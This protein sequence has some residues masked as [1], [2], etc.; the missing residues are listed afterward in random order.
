MALELQLTTANAQKALNQI[1]SSLG[2][3]QTKLASFSGTSSLETSLQRIAAI[4]FDGSA[5]SA[6]SKLSTALNSL[7]SGGN[8]T[9]VSSELNTLANVKLNGV[10][11]SVSGLGVALKG[12]RAPS[13]MGAVASGFQSIGNAAAAASGSVNAFGSAL[14]G[15]HA[16][17]G[18][19]GAASGMQNVARGAQS[20]GTAVQGFG[21]ALGGVS[22]VLNGFGI[23]L[24]GVGL[25]QFARAAYSASVAVTQF[26]SR[27]ASTGDG[28]LNAADQLDYVRKAADALALPVNDAGKAYSKLLNTLGSNADAVEKSR[29]IFEGFGTAFR[30]MGL[31]AEQAKR[32]FQALDQ[33]MSKGT[34]SME[35]LKQQLG[36]LFPA[37]NDLAKSMGVSAAELS[38]MIEQGKVGSDVMGKFADDLREK[39]GRGLAQALTSPQAA[40]QRLENAATNALAEIGKT[41]Y[42]A[43]VPAIDELT[44]ALKQPDF[45]ATAKSA[46]ELAGVLGG[47][48]VQAAK[49]VVENFRLIASVVAALI[50][51]SVVSWATGAAIAIGTV[52]R[53]A[54]V[55]QP[56]VRAAAMSMVL[57]TSSMTGSSAA[58]AASSGI[59]ARIGAAFAAFNPVVRAAIVVMTLLGA[60]FGYLSGDVGSFESLWG[61]FVSRLGSTIDSISQFFSDLGTSIGSAL[62]YAAQVIS[63]WVSS[64]GETLSGWASGVAQMF[65][66]FF[67]FLGQLF[68]TGLNAVGQL[69]MN[70][71]TRVGQIFGTVKQTLVDFANSAVESFTNWTTGATTAAEATGSVANAAGQAGQATGNYA[72]AAG[73]A[74]ETSASL[75]QSVGEVSKNADGVASSAGFA[76]EGLTAMAQ[77]AADSAEGVGAAAVASNDLSQAANDASQSASNMGSSVSSAGSAANGAGSALSSS[78]SSAYEAAAAYREAAAAARELARAQQGIGGG[79]GGGGGGGTSSELFSGGG[80][81]H[82]GGTGSTTVPTSAFANAPRLAGGTPNTDYLNGGGIPAV[83]HPNEAVIPLTGGGAVPVD[84]SGMQPRGSSTQLSQSAS[85]SMGVF[86][87]QLAAQRAT[88]LEAARVFE[89]VSTSTA[90]ADARG[91]K[92]NEWL[93]KMHTELVKINATIG[94]AINAMKNP[95]SSGGSSGGSRGDNDQ[96]TGGGLPKPVDE[97]GFG[98]IGVGTPRRGGSSSRGG[99]SLYDNKT[100]QALPPLPL[101]AGPFGVGAHMQ[102]GAKALGFATGSPNASE[103]MY[104]GGGFNAV[105]HPDEAVIPLPDGRA[106]PVKMPKVMTESH[107][108]FMAMNKTRQQS[109]SS[110]MRMRS[111]QSQS[112]IVQQPVEVKIY[113]TAKDAESFRKSEDQIVQE[114]ETKLSRTRTILGTKSAVDDPTKLTAERRGAS[115]QVRSRGPY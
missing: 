106:V 23:A 87:D 81:S 69:I 86:D 70:F 114:L 11:S 100:L 74:S 2:E 110:D 47:A 82:K 103:D 26:N 109:G 28:T 6:I 63:S 51:Y 8:I 29:R 65:G 93:N 84:M 53:A 71:A 37:F 7:S 5:A 1:E 17:N 18:L 39:Y 56:A 19:Q 12:I 94:N 95:S 68:M 16:P 91:V 48:L 49:F 33:I 77:S 67:G 113:V 111:G 15:V 66:S 60:A 27:I 52:A 46:A 35:E 3:L 72:N 108:M 10:T 73:Q 42:E 97:T 43:L 54:I 41:F 31:N 107:K 96:V 20:A 79:G 44:N 14:G 40:F 112:Q 55:M 57:L 76:A 13:G 24:G 21:S 64:A 62:N 25:A 102:V 50:T 98:G 75:A 34:V 78:A 83:L 38:K 4:K 99:S 45:I 58:A 105:L 88:T 59:F 104:R 101:L 115:G 90:L 89:A 80:I 92:A 32:G 30:A 22:G 9:R 36:E 85:S 61:Q